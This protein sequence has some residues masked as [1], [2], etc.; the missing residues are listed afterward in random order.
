LDEVDA[1]V[2]VYALDT[3]ELDWHVFVIRTPAEIAGLAAL[4]QLRP[5]RNV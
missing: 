2:R 5:L 1:D 4:G 3:N